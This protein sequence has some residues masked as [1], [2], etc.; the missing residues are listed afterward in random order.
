MI[1]YL[2]ISR[3]GWANAMYAMKC[4]GLFNMNQVDGI[5]EGSVID[6][7]EKKF[8]GYDE[9]TIKDHLA[10]KEVENVDLAIEA[11]RWLG[12]FNKSSPEDLVSN[13]KAETPIDAISRLM[14]KKLNYK[15]GEKDMV[16]MFHTVIGEMP[17]GSVESHTSRL[18]AFGVPGGDS[19]MSATVGYTT[20]AAAD[21]ILSGELS[22][23][24]LCGILIPT[25]KR[26]YQ[27]ILDRIQKFGIHWSEDIQVQKKK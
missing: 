11:I 16:A 6:F 10:Q 15:D 7:L 27:P 4:L 23:S 5:V 1:R 2:F 17:D 14:E 13:S 26:V 9:Q 25:D 18:L 20:A 19:A 12:L 24:S 8:P 3:L 22:D 21:L